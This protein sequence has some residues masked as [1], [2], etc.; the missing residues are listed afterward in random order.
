MRKYL[1]LLLLLTIIPGM[2]SAS[3][4]R[5]VSVPSRVMGKNVDVNVITPDSEGRH[6]VVYLLHGWGGG[7]DNWLGVKPEIKRIADERDMIIVIPS[8]ENSWYWDSPVNPALQYETFT[9]KELVK[10][11]DDNF[12]TLPS[13]DKRAITGYSMGG[14][15]ALWLA[16]RHPDTFGAVGS[17]SGGVDIRPFPNNWNMKDAIGPKSKY[18]ERWEQY[19]LPNH[20][21]DFAKANLA[22]II[23]CGSDDFFFEVN[24]EFHKA[25]KKAGVKHHFIDSPGVHDSK[26]WNELTDYQLEFFNDYFDGLL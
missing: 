4:L 6:P 15:G 22:I 23:S 1:T 13:R 12:P 5:K 7:C 14:Q 2:M 20:I 8:G 18:P 3:T 9:A 16:M 19:A 25:L 21:D 10:Y 11:I 26:Y 24:E 17:L